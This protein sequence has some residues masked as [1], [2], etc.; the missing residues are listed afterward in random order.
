METIEAQW[1]NVISTSTCFLCDD[2]PDNLEALHLLQHFKAA[3]GEAIDSAALDPSFAALLSGAG[4]VLEEPPVNDLL[5]RLKTYFASNANPSEKELTKI[6]ES[7][8]IQVDVVRKWFAKMNSRK[9]VG[10]DASNQNGRAKKDSSQAISN[11][12]S[13]L[14]DSDCDDSSQLNLVIV[15]SE[16]EEADPLGFQAKVSLPNH[17]SSLGTTTPSSTQQEKLPKGQTINPP[18][19]GKHINI[20]TAAQMRFLA[21]S[22]GQS[23]VRCLS[24]INTTATRTILL[25]DIA[26]TYGVSAMVINSTGAKAFALTNNKEKRL[27]SG[28]DGVSTA[29]EKTAPRSVKR[30]KKQRLEKELHSCDLC[31][32][33]FN[34]V[35]SLIRHKYEHTGK[36]P[37]ECNV[38][39]KTFKHQH[40]LTEHSRLHSGEKP[41]QCDKCG[42]RFSHSGSYSQ[43]NKSRMTRCTKIQS[44]SDPVRG[45]ADCLSADP[46]APQFDAR[47]MT[48]TGL[49]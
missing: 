16:P 36:R 19:I 2:C 8:S 33:V 39:K 13:S 48:H 22:T 27:G 42:R 21:A 25:P 17:I 5:S 7:V 26:R 49:R 38:C 43:H 23:T 40:H 45:L 6:S 44:D 10:Q 41:F 24:S 35:C 15:K 28:S 47:T 30:M 46:H 37:F 29:V 18:R 11:I 4:V 12:A 31:S 20:I 14:S 9:Q 32:K 1:P 3:N 34:K